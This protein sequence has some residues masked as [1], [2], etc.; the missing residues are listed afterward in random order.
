MPLQLAVVPPT[1]ELSMSL[2]ASRD[3]YRRRQTEG[4]R[5]FIV[6]QIDGDHPQL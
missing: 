4:C 5:P 1:S 2:K 3:P 6:D